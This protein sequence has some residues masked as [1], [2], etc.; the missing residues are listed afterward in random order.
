MRTALLIGLLAAT[1]VPAFAQDNDT[2]AAQ[3]RA[4]SG[5]QEVTV[6]GRRIQDY[7]ARLAACI[8]RGCP[9]NEDVDASLALAEVE[10]ESGAYEDARRT[11]LQ[12]LGRNRQHARTF[13]EPVADLYR[14]RAR[15]ARHL[16][17]G[18]ESLRSTL[19]VR[20]TLQ[21][22]IPT[23]DYRHLTARLEVAEAYTRA[24][25]LEEARDELADLAR[26]ARA[27]NRPD[28]ATLAEL[29]GTWISYLLAPYGDARSRLLEMTRDPSNRMRAVGAQILLA[30]IYRDQG[31]P[32]RADQLV[33]ELAQRDTGR[34]ALVFSPPYVLQA[35][36]TI[37]EGGT[38][39]VNTRIADTFDR[40]WIDVGFWVM[41]DGRV[42]G[43]EII[44]QR[45]NTDWA[46]PLLR[47]IRGRRYTVAADNVPTF[48]LERYTYTADL[49]RVSGTR[50]MQRGQ[51]A[52]V[53]YYDLSTG[54]PPPDV[55]IPERPPTPA[56][57]PT[58]G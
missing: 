58:S 14:S 48:R 46:D 26:V 32:H 36:E 24:S 31:D 43:L 19:D 11:I 45:G 37:E 54:E 44:R 4:Q 50:I 3:P 49:E 8:A 29:R 38:V 16:G 51:R 21:A 5:G 13:P 10:F 2:P 34:R 20:R 18:D 1:S 25:R 12:S 55:A 56:P 33:A 15:V 27:I 23:E 53:E 47:S 41:P 17:H 40:T 7:R 28:V 57:R 52:R 39:N 35:R 6:T 9:P 42:D 22:G 30:R